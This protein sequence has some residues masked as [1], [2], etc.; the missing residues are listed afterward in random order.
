MDLDCVSRPGVRA[1]VLAALAAIGLAGCATTAPAP[2]AGAGAPAQ[3]AASAASAPSAAR[4]TPPVPGQ[5]PA[6]ATVVKDAT[7]IKGL[8]TLWQKDDK[9]WIELKPEDFNRPLLFSPKLA[10]GLGE[11][12]VLAGSMIVSGSRLDDHLI[13]FRRV[14]NLVQLAAV[15]TNVLA[16]DAKSPEARAVDEGFAYSLLASSAVVSQPHPQRKSVLIEAGPMFLND[17]LGI[18]AALQRTYRQNYSFE[19]RNSGFASVRGT[20]SQIVF[21]IN[22]HYYAAALAQPPVGA[23]PGTP[24]PTVPQT[25]P[26]PRSMMLGLYISIARLPETPM[27]PRL[28][29]ARIGHFTTPVLDFTNDLSRVPRQRYLRRW[30]LEKKDP[31]A[32][33]SEPVKPIVFWVD[34]SVPLKYRD[35]VMRA[36]TEWNKAFERI[37][38]K[39]AVVAKVQPDDADFDTLDVGVSSVRWLQTARPSFNGI[40]PVHVDPRSGEILDADILIDGNWGRVSRVIRS[41]VVD[42]GAA[43]LVAR[44]QLPRSP[45]E[46]AAMQHMLWCDDHDHAAELMRYG[47]EVLEAR[48]DLLPDSPE[49]E[50]FAQAAVFSTVTHEV[51]HAL[52]LRHNFRSSRA[53]SLEQLKDPAFTAAN[54]IGGSVMD[55]PDINLPPPGVPFVRHGSPFRSAIGPYDFWAI[56][57]AYRP[58]DAAQ[59]KAELQRIAAR[60]AERGLEF[61]ND[62]DAF[63]GIDAEALQWDLGD[64]P[65]AYAESRIAIARDLIARQEQ[66]GL[67]SDDNYAV[68]RRSVQWA[69]RDL[70][71][72]SGVLARQI[73]GLRTLRDH[74]GSG[75]D[76]MVPVPAA[77]QRRALDVLAR[78]VLAADSFR[79]SPALQRRLAPDFFDRDEALADGGGA[80]DY[81]VAGN[82]L[83][84]QKTLLGQLMSDALA[85]RLLDDEGKVDPR[86]SGSAFRLSELYRRLTQEIWSELGAAGDIAAPRRE[87]QREHVNRL[88]A[89]LLRPT[90]AS[91]AD[92]RS[93]LRVEAQGLLA[94]LRQAGKRAGLSAQARAHLADSADSL[95][96]ALEARLQRLGA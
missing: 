82:L 68:L 79:I 1:G 22:A 62:A 87:L 4:P 3:A 20:D 70:A 15:N 18:G 24:M 39:D 66:R 54:G 96:Q 33:L 48:G 84:V 13:E 37:G 85:A 55:Y 23:P 30:R 90:A 10:R 78:G 63:L 35:A 17:M 31:A 94:R 61:G 69:L 52:G 83:V 34:R 80:T 16:R 93:L 49:A 81:S 59:E 75:R 88:A 89:Q 71:G 56:E 92:A 43:D 95:T 5:P 41:T 60:S 76:P 50:Q 7:E 26:D 32:A 38:F 36:I 6:F 58:I 53:Y 12:M 25:L 72:A 11:G 42:G 64:D 2:G 46:V 67:P 28:A 91:R 19:S 47:L 77:L 27:T 73:G 40:G 86:E 8:I 74:P 44:L 29:D 14:H 51:G 9:V 57:Y 21:N 45:Q 65:V